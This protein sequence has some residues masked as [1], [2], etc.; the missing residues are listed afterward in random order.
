MS[1]AARTSTLAEV[2]ALSLASLHKVLKN[3]AYADQ[4]LKE[5]STGTASLDSKSTLMK[6]F[7]TVGLARSIRIDED[8][9]TTQLYGLGSPTRPVMIPNNYSVSVSIDRLQ[10]D[11][12]DN[13]S[14]ITSPDYWYSKNMQQKIGAA[15]W[16]MYTYLYIHDREKASGN[17]EGGRN[18][19][20]IYALM[21]RTASKSISSND[22]M[23]VHSVQMIGFKYQYLDFVGDLL[24]NNSNILNYGRTVLAGK[25]TS[26][27]SV[28]VPSGNSTSTTSVTPQG[29]AASAQVT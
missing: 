12:R 19:V 21:P 26:F 1:D 9:G 28:V 6:A 18:Q 15:D 17:A 16:P 10:L 20:E 25:Q 2:K 4:F 14:Y 24:N 27:G 5:L 8:W 11:T 7:V 29:A 3:K 22:V 23:L 13:F